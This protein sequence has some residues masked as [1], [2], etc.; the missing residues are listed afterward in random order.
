M[1]ILRWALHLPLCS[2]K[3][4]YNLLYQNV[5]WNFLSNMRFLVT[6]A[7][8]NTFSPNSI[9]CRLWVHSQHSHDTAT[10]TEWQLPEVVLTQFVS[11]DD[12]HDVLETCRDLKIKINTLKGICASRCSFTKNHSREKQERIVTSVIFLPPYVITSAVKCWI[13]S[14]VFSPSLKE[15]AIVSGWFLGSLRTHLEFFMLFDGKFSWILEMSLNA[16]K[17]KTNFSK[18]NQSQGFNFNS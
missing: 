17:T 6:S 5:A 1:K 11:P 3:Y 12:E 15:T 8:F 9:H 7:T 10:N 2:Q 13:F 16:E 4:S 18:N 14:I